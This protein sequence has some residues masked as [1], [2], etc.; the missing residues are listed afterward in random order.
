MAVP[1]PPIDLV[2]GAILE[3][4]K[5]PLAKRISRSERIQRAFRQLGLT[6]DPPPADFDAIYVHALVEY[7]WNKP[8]PVL[9]LWRNEQIREAFRRSFH[10]NDPVILTEEVEQLLLLNEETAILGRIDYDLRLEIEDFTQAFHGIIDRIRTPQEIRQQ[11]QLREIR[12]ELTTISDMVQSL[13]ELAKGPQGA[14]SRHATQP[15]EISIPPPAFIPPYYVE[16]SP[17]TTTIVNAL[18]PRLDQGESTPPPVILGLVGI[19]GTGK[20]TLVR[21]S[22]LD[23][24]IRE[25][26]PGGTFWID[27]PLQT[28]SLQQIL[29]DWL[30]LIGVDPRTYPTIPSMSQAIRTRLVTRPMVVVADDASDHHL[31]SALVECLPPGSSLVYTTRDPEM[32]RRMPSGETLAV[33]GFSPVEARHV[34]ESRLHHTLPDNEW[35][36]VVEPILRALGF[37]PLAT[38]LAGAQVSLG[39]VNWKQLASRLKTGLAPIVDFKDPSSASESI[40]L[41]FT[42]TFSALE[43]L[44]RRQ[45]LWL[46]VL[47]PGR[48]FFLPDAAMILSGMPENRPT[49]KGKVGK[50]GLPEHS[51]EFIE[52]QSRSADQVLSKLLRLGLLEKTDTPQGYPI[53]RFHPVLQS[54]A[55]A[56]LQA[57]DEFQSA[58]THHAWVYLSMAVSESDTLPTQHPFILSPDQPLEVLERAWSAI[59]GGPAIPLPSRDSAEVALLA[60]AT[61]VIRIWTLQGSTDRIITWGTR[62]LRVAQKQADRDAEHL[63]RRAIARAHFD[64]GNVTQAQYHFERALKLARASDGKEWLIPD[65][66]DAALVQTHIGNTEQAI[67][68]LKECETL[69]RELPTRDTLGLVLGSLVHAHLS[70]G[71]LDEALPYAQQAID[72]AIETR[73]ILS[74][75][76]RLGNLA[77]VLRFRAA[78]DL[79]RSKDLYHRSRM[80]ARRA[81]NR[82]SEA[83]HL[84][85]L[86]TI[87]MP[88]QHPTL[89]QLC[90]DRAVALFDEIRSP[91]LPDAIRT[92]STLMEVAEGEPEVLDY[93][94]IVEHAEAAV[95]GDEIARFRLQ[96]FADTVI[97]NRDKAP[98]LATLLERVTDIVSGQRDAA[99]LTRNLDLLTSVQLRLLLINLGHPGLSDVLAAVIPLA[100]AILTSDAT[101]IKAATAIVGSLEDQPTGTEAALAT[102]LRRALDGETDPATLVAE[103]PDP[104]V[105][106]TVEMMLSLETPEMHHPNYSGASG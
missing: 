64:Q 25:R 73:D 39:D 36:S 56:E 31:L 83:K 46:S 81:G 4:S 44:L 29:A 50:L 55:L 23:Q 63:L 42:R 9:N 48:P 24:R 30:N 84:M 60:I 77:S 71:L 43:P 86:A 95:Q 105:R 8:E 66:V 87:Y 7:G 97:Q 100:K 12:S 32:S 101:A 103:I 91:L 16:R 22:L 11:N 88:T 17:Y 79:R 96:R 1:T 28:V 33:E 94:D 19:G 3:I 14:P 18:A 5:D 69:A 58:L 45:L 74:L 72:I 65:L 37:H 62:A 27:Q 49:F 34:I 75:G 51:P 61:S 80:I 53:Y 57:S 85:N 92:R 78:N 54:A 41:T 52:E 10:R 93:T 2:L 82:Q 90:A 67:K 102:L 89:G 13:S 68:I 38:A 99:L 70:A 106:E 6:P 98:D 76:I 15:F 104:A 40:T 20:S 47:S 35:D 26:F 59:D 21:A